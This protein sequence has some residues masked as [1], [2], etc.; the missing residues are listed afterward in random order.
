M[1][2]IRWGDAAVQCTALAQESTEGA[3]RV[4]LSP[5]KVGDPPDKSFDAAR[6]GT[7]AAGDLFALPV[8]RC[9]CTIQI[10]QT[11]DGTLG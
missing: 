9:I 6:S 11:G 10:V 8:A 5:G 3:S 7:A 2:F 4:A 1:I